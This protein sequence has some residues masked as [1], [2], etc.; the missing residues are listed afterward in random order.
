MVK[1]QVDLSSRS[2]LHVRLVKARNNLTNV[3]AINL[4]L[5]SYVVEA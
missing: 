3:E 4:M 1:V 5:E 2:A